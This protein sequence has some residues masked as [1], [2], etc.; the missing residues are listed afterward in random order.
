MKTMTC[1]TA[2]A[3][4]LDYVEGELEE[5]R[6]PGLQEHVAACPHCRRELQEIE[7]LRGVLGRERVPDPGAAFWA[8]FPDRVWQAYRSEQSAAP[9][10]GPGAR[11]G[12]MLERALAPRLWVPAAAMLALVTGVALFF[13]LERSGG[14]DI[15]AFQARIQGGHSLKLNAQRGVFELPADRS[16][17]FS[18]ASGRVDFF[19]IGHGYAE[20]LAYAASGDA[21]TARLRLRA[22]AESLDPV[23]GDLAA[24]AQGRPSPGQIAA[25]EPELARIAAGAG[26]REATLFRAG[27]WLAN[28]ALAAAAR[29]RSAMRDAAPEIL[30]LRQELESGGAAP[31]ALRNLD[32]LARLLTGES[33]SDRDYAEAARLIREIQLVLI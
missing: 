20:S 21:E 14:P 11:I 31:G 10:L 5:A 19:R 12:A 9:R 13:P 23:P 26:T 4:L 22:I 3:Q 27:G 1:E 17:G 29:D 32:T 24:L 7:R 28:I 30:R 25:L 18:A 2:Q 16:L 33:F 6:R 8:E 15:A